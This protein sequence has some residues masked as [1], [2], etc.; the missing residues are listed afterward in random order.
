MFTKLS[1][2]KNL[3]ETKTFSC[4]P[5]FRDSVCPITSV[6]RY[7]LIKV[8]PEAT[9]GVLKMATEDKEIV[10]RFLVHVMQL[11]PRKSCKSQETQKMLSVSN[12]VPTLLPFG[13]VVS[14]RII[15]HVLRFEIHKSRR[16]L[17]SR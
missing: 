4:Y 3:K 5:S 10:G 11:L 15:V 1:N 9:W 16:Y 2:K 8:P 7:R 13:V 17:I 14:D 6:K 12:E